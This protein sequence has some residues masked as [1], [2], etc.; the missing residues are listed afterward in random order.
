MNGTYTLLK[1]QTTQKYRLTV[2]WELSQWKKK[3]QI[4]QTN[5]SAMVISIELLTP[6]ILNT[7]INNHSTVGNDKQT[8]RMFTKY[9]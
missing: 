2:I 3:N 6:E 7:Y 8:I 5:F 9:F 4:W 1:R